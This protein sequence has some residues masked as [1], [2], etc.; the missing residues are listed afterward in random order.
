MQ[1]VYFVIYNV[2]YKGNINIKIGS[3]GLIA[4]QKNTISLYKY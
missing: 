1:N 2:E 3:I 4:I